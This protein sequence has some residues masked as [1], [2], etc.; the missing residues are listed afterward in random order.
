[1][2]TANFDHAS[3][4][5]LLPAA[6]A[7]MMPFLETEYGNPQSLH[8][9][10]QK[11]REA[12]DK[13][14]E[15]VAALLNAGSANRIVFTASASESNNLAL[16]GLA[17]ARQDKGKHIVVSAIEHQS[18]LEP[19]RALAKLGFEVTELPVDRYGLVSPDELAKA[20][21]ADTILVSIQHASNEIGTIQDIAALAEVAHE[22]GALFHSDGT[23]AVGRIPV[24]VQA[25]GV[26]A[27]SFSAQSIYG[28][29]G[30]AALYLKQGARPLSLVHGGIQ[31]K[32]KR[33]G[34]ENVPGIVGMGAAAEV[35]ARDLAGWSARMKSLSDRLRQ[36]LPDRLEHIVLTGHPENRLP[37]HFSV[38]IEFV[39]G[40][41]MLLFLNDEGFA[42]AS[43]S[44]CTAKTLKASHVLLAIGL[45]VGKA[46]SS[47]VLTLGKDSTEE[48]VS[49]FLDALPP[50]IERLRSMS[51][52]YA[53]FQK[54]E[55]PYET[56]DQS[57][58]GE[59]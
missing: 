41:A 56:H 17:M 36:E 21:R 6:L 42:T 25:L 11:P 51:P 45:P 10:G 14:R 12:V 16:K 52:L 59:H 57:C 4:T 3:A 53:R 19:A 44:A 22:H 23:A 29:K 38:C 2:K 30:T 32:G 35:T 5:P 43:G 31:E 18:V 40:E 39:E 46:Q 54:G 20:L 47:L 28:P 37:G 34:T 1:M 13:A 27:Y 26:D 8:S 7:A 50:I 49:R 24:D 33:A 15:Q 9:L 48:Q 55:D 58:H